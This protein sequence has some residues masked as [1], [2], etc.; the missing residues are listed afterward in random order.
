M[1]SPANPF[2]NSSLHFFCFSFLVLA[3]FQTPLFAFDSHKPFDISSDMLEYDDGAQ[4]LTA[5]GHVVVVQG[6][7]TLHADLVLYDRINKRMNARGNVV[8]RDK[9]GLLMGDIMDYDMAKESIAVDGGRGFGSPWYFQGANWEKRLDYLV[10]KRMSFTTCDLIDP[11]YHIRASRVKL[12]P[13]KIFW[14]WNNVFY[15]DTYPVFYTPFLYKSFGPRRVVVQVQPGHDSVKGSIAKTVTTLRLFPNAYDKVLVDY[16]SNSGT[17][18]GNE[19]NY[20]NGNYKGSLFGYFIDPKGNTR[21]A[22]APTDPQYNVRFYHWQNVA[23]GM[24][25]QSNVNHRK[26]VSFNNQFFTQDTNYAVN[27][28]NNSMALTYL[29]NIATQR[30][31]VESFEAP[32][33]NSDSL[34][35][36]THIQSAS[37]PRYEVAFY[38]KPLWSPVI[39]T[40]TLEQVLHPNH[41]GALQLSGSGGVENFY[42]RTDDQTRLRA[43]ASTSLSAPV[44]ISRDLSFSASLSPS[45]RWQDKYDPFIPTPSTGP[46]I[47]PT[48]IF[49]GYQGR[50]GSG[51]NLR[52]RPFSSI[53]LDNSYSYTMRL[54][55]NSLG[56]DQSLQ[57]GGVETNRLNW[58]LFARPSRYLL[59]R[60]FSGYDMRRLSEEDPN[61]FRQRRIDPWTNELT[62]YRPNSTTS[63]FFRHS[64]GYYPTRTTLWQAETRW[65]FPH[66]SVFQTG[67]NYN[68]GQRGVVTWNNTAGFYFSPS[69]R[70]DGIVNA[71]M[72]SK[73]L[74]DVGKGD[75]LQTTFIVTREVHCWS[76][77]FIHKNLPPF[78]HEY[79]FL[80]NL[81]LGAQALKEMTNN[82]LESQFYPWRAD[83]RYSR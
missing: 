15:D 81:R 13:D 69:W 45:V 8:I 49:R 24:T 61:A 31:V 1:R 56:L 28:V 21:L 67:L 20:D 57:D 6:S 26:N 76:L 63:Y 47:I 68:A 2:R 16:Y 71:N 64:L 82:E 70:V 14:A 73:N 7:S 54:K 43:N 72:Q 36:N 23:P 29:N 40:N 17:G 38:Q 11:H 9:G 79:S 39:S 19:F 83:D 27:D 25:Y 12:I 58:L 4:I 34:F 53:T 59:M 32:D 37:L 30:V 33:E 50:L 55:Q 10:G 75:V 66:K 3:A 52:Y 18:F 46:V 51:A 60:S 80:F 78:T 74:K 35:G 48:G 77:Q 22:G 5:E 65:T 42:S 44:N 62:L 41:L